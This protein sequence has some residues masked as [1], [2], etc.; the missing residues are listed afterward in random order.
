MEE[1]GHPRLR[2][3]HFPFHVGPLERDR[4]LVHMAAAVEHDVLR[5]R[6]SRRCRRRIDGLLRAGGRAPPQ[7]H[8]PP[9]LHVGAQCGTIAFAPACPSSTSRPA[10]ELW[11]REGVDGLSFEVDAGEVY[12]LLGENGAGKST[13]VEILEGHRSATSGCVE[14]LG[15]DPSDCRS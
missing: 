11:R 13:A 4:W 9:D 3:R 2:M 15:A 1:R 14:V 5:A 6:A 8:G 12:A 10:Q 7:R